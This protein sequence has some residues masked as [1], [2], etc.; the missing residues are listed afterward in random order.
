MAEEQITSPDQ[1]RPTN[2]KWVRL[3]GIVAIVAL[4]TMLSPFGG[5]HGQTTA[6]GVL[7]GLVGLIAAMMIGD[8]VLRRNG[9]RR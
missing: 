8:V 6:D 9:L 3:A 2:R 1:R 7:I 5:T 4:L